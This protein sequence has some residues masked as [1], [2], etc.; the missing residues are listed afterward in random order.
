MDCETKNVRSNA[1]IR[2]K[3]TQKLVTQILD[4]A[5]SSDLNFQMR[6]RHRSI[7]I[8]ADLHFA[9]FL[10][11]DVQMISQRK[12]NAVTSYRH[13]ILP[14]FRVAIKT[15]APFCTDD[16]LLLQRIALSHTL[17]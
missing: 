7:V 3:H 12:T 15:D 11:G 8:L 10:K 4:E 5:A 6:M 17:P 1:C 16:T 2:K 13:C 14:A 9:R